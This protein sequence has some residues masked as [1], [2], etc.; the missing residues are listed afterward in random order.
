MGGRCQFFC[1]NLKIPSPRDHQLPLAPRLHKVWHSSYTRKILCVRRA[2]M[3]LLTILTILTFPDNT[4]SHRRSFPWP[5]AASTPYCKPGTWS[6][7]DQNQV[8]PFPFLHTSRIEVEHWDSEV[9]SCLTCA[10]KSLW[11]FVRA[12][13]PHISGYCRCWWDLTARNY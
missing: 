13:Y 5:Q 11:S 7:L 2:D 3:R 8:L 4:N 1:W 6:Y 9:T 12:Y 10:P